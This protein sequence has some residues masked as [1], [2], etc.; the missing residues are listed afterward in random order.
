MRQIHF[1][2]NL[3]MESLRKQIFRDSINEYKNT[4][5]SKFSFKMLFFLPSVKI[6]SQYSVQ[7]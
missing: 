5:L 2:F 3:K 6:L 7:P 4:F 1:L